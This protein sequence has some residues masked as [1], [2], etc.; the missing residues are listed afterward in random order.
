MLFD[1]QQYR[2]D[3]LLFFIS[4]VYV[5]K[6]DLTSF[7]LFVFLSS[8]YI[9]LSLLRILLRN[10]HI[11]TMLLITFVLF[12]LYT[13]NVT[14]L[15]NGNLIGAIGFV[16]NY[17]VIFF[18]VHAIKDKTYFRRYTYIYSLGLLAA[19]MVRFISFYVPEIGHFIE[20]MTVVNTVK[21]MN[22]A[23][24]TRFAGL[25]LDPNYFSLQVL[26]AISCLLVLFYVEGKMEK[27]SSALIISLA[28]FGMLSFSKMFIITLVFLITLT[29]IFFFKQQMKTA[30]KLTSFVVVIGGIGL[31]Y[32]YE[33]LYEIYW[34]R[35]FGAGITSDAI[36]TGRVK[37][38]GIFANEIVQNTKIFVFGAGFGTDLT[39]GVMAHTMYL[40]TPY[41]LG[42]F[43]VVFALLYIWQ[44]HNVL[45]KN[46]GVIGIGN[47]RF[48]AVINL[49]LFIMLF[50]N[51]VLDSFI[52]DYFPFHIL[53]IMLALSMKKNEEFTIS[54][55]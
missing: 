32:F 7:S 46:I 25:D 23:V 49:P 48:L 24:N 34:N 17:S 51:M 10:D 27:R 22:D 14:L 42:I 39:S 37:N 30:V 44:L 11:Q 6:F 54:A 28:T 16:L 9:I 55:R 35:F 47:F 12:S 8:F 3:Y 40:S 20:S 13:V 15:S 50:T 4:W 41:Y 5:I 21:T 2:F 53:L 36:T 33:Q 31:Y 18:A 38:W 26:I 29:I 19:S 1:K 45:Q 52:M 43:G